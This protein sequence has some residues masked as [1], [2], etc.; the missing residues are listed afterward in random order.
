MELGTVWLL[1]SAAVCDDPPA[2]R[3]DVSPCGGL[4]EV[5]LLE[6]Q[7][8]ASCGREAWLGVAAQGEQ[9]GGISVADADDANR[10]DWLTE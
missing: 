7:S 4:R 2:V 10:E 5:K 8:K 1:H 6:L 9:G 3:W